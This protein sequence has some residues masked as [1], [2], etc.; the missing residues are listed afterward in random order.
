MSGRR[1]GNLR[2]NRRGVAMF[3][4]FVIV[5]S[6]LLVATSVI[7]MARAER[8][9]SA[10]VKSM[11][12][13]RAL[14]WSGVQAVMAELDSQRDILLDGDLPELTSQWNLYG[15]PTERGL[16]TVVP[17]GT[18]GDL[19]QSES[20]KIDLNK[21]D[22]QT[23]E[24][25]PG[26]S[27]QLA[28][29]IV[30]RRE[31]GRYQ[32]LGD[33]LDV[34]GVTAAMIW[35]D[36]RSMRVQSNASS[37]ETDDIR[38]ARRL[39]AMAADLGQFNATG[40]PVPLRDLVTVF[41][42]E[43]VVQS[44]GRLKININGEFDA[45]MRSRIEQRFGEDLANLV[46]AVKQDGREFT[47]SEIY[48]TM[49]ASQ[50]PPLEWTKYID[51]FTDSDESRYHGRIDILRARPEV[52]E[53]IGLEP[54][55]VTAI[56]ASRDSL[57]RE[58]QS[59]TSWT[60][61]QGCME[62]DRWAEVGPDLTWRSFVYRVRVM[63][64]VLVGEDDPQRTAR[65]AAE[66]VY[67]AVIDMSAPRP[68]IAYL[69][70]ISQLETASRLYEAE[71]ESDIDTEAPIEDEPSA[72]DETESRLPEEDD[73][74]DIDDS[75]TDSLSPPPDDTEREGDPLLSPD[76]GPL[77]PPET[78]DSPDVPPVEPVGRWRGG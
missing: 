75:E 52:L 6:S 47:M 2:R 72:T 46:E 16:I 73:M 50:E 20:G 1:I 3:V 63:G 54:E 17:I 14:A 9:G 19:V 32:S 56:M 15:T 42:Y 5:A 44:T 65:L 70:D 8:T 4:A 25:L 39:D 13:A 12:Q 62:G 68:R 35:G 41:N 22:A 7:M 51:G 78:D 18:G 11:A 23:L 36:L 59:G 48:Q 43:P 29:A 33:L 58:E 40:D 66:V 60:V 49:V 37:G 69:R 64:Q 67:E 24:R 10:G 57:S 30:T 74:T 27:T 31:Q 53:A 76:E 21:A 26:I 28:Q 45:T 71:S 77:T 38:F 34:N 61:D 55:S